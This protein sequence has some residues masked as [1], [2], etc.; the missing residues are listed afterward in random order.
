MASTMGTARG[1]TGIV[2]SP[3]LQQCG[4]PFELQSV[5]PEISSPLFED[6]GNSMRCHYRFRPG[7][8][9]SDWST[10]E[11]RPTFRPEQTG[12]Y[13]SSP[14]SATSGTRFHFQTLW[15]RVKT[16]SLSPNPPPVYHCPQ[17]LPEHRQPRL[18]D[19]TDGVPLLS[20]LSNSFHFSEANGSGQ[21]TREASTA[22]EDTFNGSICADIV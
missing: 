13:G 5:V 22:S 21:R 6:H 3:I 18:D 10:F 17:A 4:F 20:N 15:R 8:H 9:L 11:S 16:T 19:A 14:S 2:T 1:S 12:R 7:S